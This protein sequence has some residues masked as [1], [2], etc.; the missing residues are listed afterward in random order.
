MR[1]HES[2]PQIALCKVHLAR[3]LT[4]NYNPIDPPCKKP[5]G[6]QPSKANTFDVTTCAMIS[7]C[8]L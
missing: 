1:D 7:I 8:L 6:I 3:S 5:L 4:T 2:A